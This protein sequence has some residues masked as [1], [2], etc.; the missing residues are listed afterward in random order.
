MP[1]CL[2]TCCVARRPGY[3]YWNVYLLIFLITLIALTVY[4]V[5]PE[6]PQSRLQITCSLI[7][8]ES[9]KHEIFFRLSIGTLL[10]TSIMFRWSVS[11]LLPPVSYL[12]LLD[13][14]TLMSL[15]FISLNSIWHS[16][17]GILIRRMGISKSVDYYVLVL[18]TL[19]FIV[20]HCLMVFSLYQA[21]HSRQVMLESDRKY[22][23]KLAGMFETFVQGHHAVQRFTDRQNSS[24]TSLF[25]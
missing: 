7:S 16:I 14:Y 13:K 24:H 6:L 17:I 1:F 2:V 10:L 19:F 23:S 4:G 22:A 3:F 8:T 11:R 12:T 5:A 20:Y 25:V 21:L 9:E 15:V 18:F